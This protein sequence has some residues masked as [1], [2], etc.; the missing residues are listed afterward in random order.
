MKRRVLGRL[1][2]PPT[3]PAHRPKTDGVLDFLDR[4]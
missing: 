1:D 3:K 2:E 4:L